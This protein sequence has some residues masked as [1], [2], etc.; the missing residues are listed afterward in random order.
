MEMSHCLH[1]GVIIVAICQVHALLLLFGRAWTTAANRR[2]GKATVCQTELT[3][4]I[5]LWQVCKEI[6]NMKG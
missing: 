1:I 6:K 4:F 3:N 5:Q 2:R